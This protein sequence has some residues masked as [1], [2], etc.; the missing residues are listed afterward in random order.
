M[1]ESDIK[2]ILEN[3]E[4]NAAHAANFSEQWSQ[5]RSAFGGIAAAFATTAMR[6]ILGSPQ[7]I[8]SLMVS[9]VAPLPPGEFI[10]EPQIIRQGRNV[11][12][13]SANVISNGQICLQALAAFGNSREG[14]IVP[15]NEGFNPTPREQGISFESQVKRM[16]SFLKFFEGSWVDGGRPF[17]GKLSRKLN[18]WVRH[19][20]DLSHFPTEEIVTLADIP[21]PVIL[22]QFD[23]PPVPSASLSWSLEFVEAPESIET[24]WFYLEFTL[25]AAAN[26]YTQQSGKIFDESGR[27]VA[28]TRQCMVYFT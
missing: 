4:G 19:R 12:Q 18:M 3:L 11:T 2:K 28:L 22:T 17:A 25:E 7:Q 14:L 26:G 13:A 10:V 20:A 9:F 16:P 8:R 23:T 24:E 6:K 21:P 27:L 15:A 1:L 5:G